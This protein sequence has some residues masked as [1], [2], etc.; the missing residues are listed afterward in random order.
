VFV[1]EEYPELQDI[2]NTVPLADMVFTFPF[3]IP[4]SPQPV[5]KEIYV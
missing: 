5:K 4:I 1:F 2:D 3:V